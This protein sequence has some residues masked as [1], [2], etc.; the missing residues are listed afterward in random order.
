MNRPTVSSTVT[1]RKFNG[2]PAPSQRRPT[3]SST[4]IP[5]VS[6]TVTYRNLNGDAPLSLRCRVFL[7][8][9]YQYVL[10]SSDCF[11][12]CSTDSHAASIRLR[13]GL[14]SVDVAIYTLRTINLKGLEA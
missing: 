3:V 4:V 8:M 14:A 13:R 10:S 1:Y 12:A 9:F 5:T 7:T 2:F 6:S 11:A